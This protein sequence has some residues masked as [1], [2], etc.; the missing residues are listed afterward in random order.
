M[1]RLSLATMA[2]LSALLP[3]GLSAQ[4]RPKP[5]DAS[6]TRL[7]LLV[8]AFH[9]AM[10]RDPSE[11]RRAEVRAAVAKRAIPA[12]RE[13][14]TWTLARSSEWDNRVRCA[15]LAVYGLVLGDE[16]YAA[17]TGSEVPDRLRSAAAALVTAADAAQ[18]QTAVQKLANALTEAAKDGHALDA[19]MG[20]SLAVLRAAAPDAEEAAALA[21]ACEGMGDLAVMFA[22]AA[23]DARADVRRLVG[24][25][26]VL[27]G[28]R[29]DGTDFST[30]SLQGKVVLVDVWAS[31][32]APCKRLLPEVEALRSRFAAQGLAVVGISCDNNAK[33]LDD[34]LAAHPQEDWPQLFDAAKPGWHALATGMGIKAIPRLL[35]IDRHG[36][37]RNADAGKDLA[38]Q[39]AELLAEQG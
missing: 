23:A 11:L 17:S 13:L 39:V 3:V 8:D 12:I 18:R 15:E 7:Q 27:A 37:L 22:T 38:Q 10:P 31:W 35:L 1:N 25:P 24:K 4:E 20:S 36:V 6:A 29:R 14:D 19:A 30:A 16:R 33:A 32:C 2:L 5:V 21:A 26:L 9:R 28:P 34:F